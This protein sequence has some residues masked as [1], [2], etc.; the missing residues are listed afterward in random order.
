MRGA[1]PV[2]DRR[3][4][5]EGDTFLDFPQIRWSLSHMRETCGDR[6][7]LARGRRSLAVR[8][9]RKNDEI[10]ALTFP[11]TN[12][13]IRNFAE[14]LF[15]TYTDGILVLHRG[16]IVYERYFGALESHLPLACHS[17]TK[18]YAGTLAASFVHEGVLDDQKTILSY[19]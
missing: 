5:F 13:R 7:G 15:D 8:Y 18:S 10:D 11:D 4:T 1:P 2:V 17:I 3:I 19:L 9:E 12:G 16:C 6:Q 14:A